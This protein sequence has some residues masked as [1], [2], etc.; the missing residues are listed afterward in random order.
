MKKV[1][2]ITG[3]SSGIGAATAI[4]AGKLGYSVCIHYN[5]NEGG[6]MEI[7]NQLL[8]KGA[9]AAIFKADLSRENE[10]HNLFNAIENQYGGLDVLVNN[11]GITLPQMKLVQ[12]TAARIKEHFEVNTLSTLL[13]SKEAIKRMAKSHGH[14][15]GAIIN[16]SSMAAIL[17][18][19]NEYVDYA[20]T[21][22]AI[23]TFT[24]GL[25][26]EVAMENIRVNAV[27]PGLIYTDLH[28]KAGEKSRVDRLKHMVPMQRG[29]MPEEVAK[30]ILW[31]ASDDA[32]YI[33]G[34]IL[35]VSGGR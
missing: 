8:A 32:S 26:K 27:R 5:A 1:I 19:P 12:M 35:N 14:E 7:K 23:D 30:A 22:G 15:G 6:A 20:A 24:I 25:S 31:L 28:E 4:L 17:G 33:T 13:C 29:G 2:L 9:D 18:S 16:V 10:I 34:S 3:A 11:A 21:K